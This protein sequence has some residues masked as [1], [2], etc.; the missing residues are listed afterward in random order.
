M[1]GA[2]TEADMAAAWDSAYWH[3]TSHQGPLNSAAVN[4]RNPYL[5]DASITPTTTPTKACRVALKTK[6]DRDASPK[7]VTASEPANSKK[8]IPMDKVSNAPATVRELAE[9][10]AEQGMSPSE[11]LEKLL[12]TPAEGTSL[13]SGAGVSA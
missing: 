7:S 9:Q 1:G 6:K 13:P 2:Y 8:E 10:A 11:L 3:G 5:K 12:A 4:A